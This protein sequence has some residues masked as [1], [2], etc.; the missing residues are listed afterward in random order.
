M[1]L[2]KKILFYALLLLLT[3][4]AVEGMARIAWY[5][6]YGGGYQVPAPPDSLAD[7]DPNAG[8]GRAEFREG[9]AARHSQTLQPFYGYTNPS[10]AHNLNAMPP[11]QTG[12]D[13][14]VIAL[15]GGSV[16]GQL[17]PYFRQ[18]VE[19]YFAEQELPR[20]PIVL[21]LAQGR[22]KQPQQLHTVSY[23][24]TMGGGFDFIVN[25]DGYNEL[26]ETYNNVQRGVFPFFPTAWNLMNAPTSDEIVI[27]G[28]ILTLRRELAELQPD[29]QGSP[30]RYSAVYGLVNRYRIQRVEDRILQLNYAL[31][32]V[33]TNRSFARHG[34]RGNFRNI[35][36]V[37]Q[38]AVRVW[39]R[40]SAILARVA[41]SAGADYYHFLQPNQYVPDSKP[42]SPEERELYYREFQR[43]RMDYPQIYPMLVHYG[44]ELQ[45]RG[46]NYFDLTGIFR[47]HTETL[48]NDRCCHLNDRGNELLAAAIV[49]RMAPA[50][51]RRVQGTGLAADSM[52]AVAAPPPLPPLPSDPE[53]T[54]P[55]GGTV[56]SAEP[57]F[58]VSRRYGN[59]LAYEKDNC[60]LEHTQPRFF[61]HIIPVS[62]TDLPEIRREHGFENRDFGFLMDGGSRI[63]GHCLI[64]R[65]LPD[66]PIANIR[67]G[68]LNSAGE[69][70]AVELSLPE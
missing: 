17:T 25:L 59:F 1:T 48:Y 35:D 16:A 53:P 39:Y 22:A 8:V 63:D 51:L 58:Q 50:L 49:Q 46:V 4:A 6:A 42:L 3:L 37:R 12:G 45:Q 20:Q 19:Q 55:A 57:Q 62:A 38:E 13:T 47:D 60:A 10:P 30:F 66:Y 44:Q 2:R 70:W 68:Q 32:E 7:T 43:E 69:I 64:E 27:A 40:S 24:L 23:A 15:L 67:T 5:L 52:L 9:G 11:P 61:L 21:E 18:A 33:E 56:P 41:E 26:A 34:P 14:V 31:T 28:R 36:E 54:I 29:G 65:P